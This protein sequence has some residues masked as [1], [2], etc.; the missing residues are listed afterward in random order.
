MAKK[1]QKGS[2]M[3]GMN[4]KIKAF[5]SAWACHTGCWKRDKWK[6]LFPSRNFQLWRFALGYCLS[7]AA[8]SCQP[9]R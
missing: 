4:S 9:F 7:F 2:A 6:L 5:S 3:P 8:A 1:S